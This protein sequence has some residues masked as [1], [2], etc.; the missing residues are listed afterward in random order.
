MPLQE[1][2]AHTTNIPGQRA[3][4][5]LNPSRQQ[6]LPPSRGLTLDD[7]QLTA[8]PVTFN[9]TPVN[10]NLKSSALRSMEPAPIR[11]SR[12]PMR[13]MKRRPSDHGKE[14]TIKEA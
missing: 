10:N 7:Q 3:K 11:E 5:P 4:P 2:R 9:K 12:T 1:D 8:P 13:T 6:K 14:I